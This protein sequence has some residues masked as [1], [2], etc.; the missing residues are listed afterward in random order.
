MGELLSRIKFNWKIIII[1]LITIFLSSGVFCYYLWTTRVIPEELLPEA[2]NKTTSV[3]AY[4]YEVA[5]KLD[6]NG[7][8]RVLSHV[9]GERNGEEFHLKGVIA[10]QDVEV[11]YVDNTVYMKDST[12][13]RWMTNYAGE[14]FQQ[15]LFMVEINPID[16]LNYKS[17]DNIVYLGTEKKNSPAYVMEYNPIVKNEMLNTYWRDFKY[18]VWINK[19][20]KRINKVEVFADHRDNPQNGLHMQLVLYDM[21]KQIKIEAPSD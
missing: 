1:I 8:D 3:N 14:I 11:Y 18:R 2:I 9:K 6:L 20:F 10:A 12:S 5:L 19:S 7:E 21:Q 13:D 15:D 16:S 4:R 17:L